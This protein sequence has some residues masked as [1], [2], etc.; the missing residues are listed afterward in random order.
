MINEKL[1]RKSEAVNAY[2]HALKTGDQTLSDA[3]KNRIKAAIEA[4]K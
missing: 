2:K 4:L 1:G 3:A